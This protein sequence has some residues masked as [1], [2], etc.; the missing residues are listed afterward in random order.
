MFSKFIKCEVQLLQEKEIIV[1]TIFVY[2]SLWL[3]ESDNVS[4]LSDV[5]TTL[6]AL[7]L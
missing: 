1:S 7:S 3:L 5:S 6:Y 2:I 4:I